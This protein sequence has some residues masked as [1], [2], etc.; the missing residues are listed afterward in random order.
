MRGRS[1]G[2]NGKND[3]TKNIYNYYKKNLQ[4]FPE[5]VAENPRLQY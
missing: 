1:K 4:L 3:E 2:N 5:L